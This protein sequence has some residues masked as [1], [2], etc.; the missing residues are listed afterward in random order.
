VALTIV[1]VGVVVVVAGVVEVAAVVLV[2]KASE[3][4]LLY[5]KLPM[6]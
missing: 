5:E 6:S 3:S 2:V 1:L 4:G